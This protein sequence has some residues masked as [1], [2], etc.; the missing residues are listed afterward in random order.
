[1]ETLG[2]IILLDQPEE[3]RNILDFDNYEI[4]NFG[5]VKNKITGRILKQNIS[6]NGYCYT[7]LSRQGF[8]KKF[9]I[10]RLV[11]NAFLQNS[12]NYPSID[13]IDNVKTNNH[14][15]NLRFCSNSQNN[16]NKPPSKNN[17]SGRRGVHFDK[18]ANKWRACVR[19]DGKKISCGSFSCIDD[20]IVAREIAEDKYFKEFRYKCVKP[21]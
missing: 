1:M 15:S 19:L 2:T 8:V 6:D 4:S 7:N 3:F 9:K 21:T 13:H 14:V 5:T 10:H 18:F 16:M 20:A 11:A 17:T 12:L